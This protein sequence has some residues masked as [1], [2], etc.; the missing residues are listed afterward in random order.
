MDRLRG[1]PLEDLRGGEHPQARR[2]RVGALLY[3]LVFRELFEFRLM[4]TDPNLA[5]YLWL[6]REQKLG[7]LDFGATRKLPAELV[8]RVAL[9]RPALSHRVL[10]SSSD[11][12]C[13]A[14]VLPPKG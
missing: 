7:L 2:D 3:R 6:A 1:V 9:V 5:N 14:I 4:Q 13:C 8:A 10:V 11:S 12:G